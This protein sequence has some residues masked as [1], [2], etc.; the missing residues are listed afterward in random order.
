[1]I[2]SEMTARHILEKKEIPKFSSLEKVANAFLLPQTFPND[3]EHARGKW[4]CA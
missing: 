3:G 4:N 1:M 2:L